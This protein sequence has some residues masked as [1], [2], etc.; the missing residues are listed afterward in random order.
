MELVKTADATIE[1]VWQCEKCDYSY[2]G[3]E[4]FLPV[5]QCPQCGA[6]WSFKRRQ[7]AEHS[8]E[9]PS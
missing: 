1:G 9:S 8:E 7:P 3:G 5:L 6:R 2:H 4:Y